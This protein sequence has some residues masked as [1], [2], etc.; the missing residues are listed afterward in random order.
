MNCHQ[1]QNRSHHPFRPSMNR[2]VQSILEASFNANKKLKAEHKLQLACQL[3]LPPRQVAIW[4]QNRRARQKLEVKE[5]QYNNIQ[6][7]LNNVLA[8]NI[9]LEKE[10]PGKE[11][12]TYLN[13]PVHV[14]EKNT[15]NQG[16][17]A[18][19]MKPNHGTNCGL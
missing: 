14:L 3:G 18:E 16:L 12:R 5:H 2:A 8:E 11:L 17:L 13:G 19:P 15:K 10:F 4:Y 6:Q 1:S 7:E 9:R